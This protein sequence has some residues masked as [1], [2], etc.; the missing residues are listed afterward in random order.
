MNPRLAAPKIELVKI[1]WDTLDDMIIMW[2]N[3]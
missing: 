2:G 3:S 1:D